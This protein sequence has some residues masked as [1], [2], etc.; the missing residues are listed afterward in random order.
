MVRCLVDT[1]P[2]RFSANKLQMLSGFAD[3]AV[4]QL[5]KR[6][7]LCRQLST[8]RKCAARGRMSTCMIVR[9]SLPW[10]EIELVLE[11]NSLPLLVSVPATELTGACSAVFHATG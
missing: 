7:A 6:V 3:L 8:S 1:T 11:A 9:R 10:D 4:R 2:R 5:E